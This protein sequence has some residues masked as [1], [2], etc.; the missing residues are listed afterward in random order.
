[1][2]EGSCLGFLAE[3]GLVEIRRYGERVRSVN[4]ASR[5]AGVPRRLI[6]KTLV[7][8]IDGRTTAFIVRGDCRLSPEKVKE[9]LRVGEARP[10]TPEEV[11]EAT[12]YS[13]GGV[14]PVCL[15]RL[16]LVVVD[17]RVLEVER[18]VGGGGDEWSL[19]WVDTAT[20]LELVKPL[21]EDVAE[22]PGD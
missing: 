11:R 17:R 1:M 12:G 9:R 5:V 10:A 13:V 8:K 18:V 21:V 15:E 3:N 20:L 22:C 4:H 2:G 7:W 19:L 14:P 6:V 16:D